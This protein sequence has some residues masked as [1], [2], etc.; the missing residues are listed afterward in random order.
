[1]Q[2]SWLNKCFALHPPVAASKAD[3]GIQNSVYS[4]GPYHPQTYGLKTA[5]LRLP[6]EEW[7]DI[8]KIIK[9]LK[10]QGALVKV[11]TEVAR[12]ERKE[13]KSGFRNIRS[14]ASIFLAHSNPS[15]IISKF[16]Q[17]AV[18]TSFWF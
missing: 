6:D 8:M 18:S 15:K 13:H 5:T 1:M 17:S 14:I 11:V 12:N 2:Y 7:N 9:S 4:S 3:S 10:N 16:E